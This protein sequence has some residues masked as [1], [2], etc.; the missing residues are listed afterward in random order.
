MRT[1]KEVSDLAGVSV[2]TLQHYDNVGLLKPS[3]YSQAGYRL[4]GDDDLERLQ[5]ILFFKEL[6][7]SLKGIKEI[8]DSE[9]FDKEEALKEQI[10]LLTLKKERLENLIKFAKEIQKEGI[11]CMKFEAFDKEKIERYS[12]EAR[13]KWGQTEAYKEFEEKEKNRSGKESELAVEQLMMIFAEFGKI[14]GEEPGSESAQKLVKKLQEHITKNYYTC[15]NEILLGL[16]KMYAAGGEFTTNIDKYGGD[17][18]ASFVN[19]AIE[20]YCNS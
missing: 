1:V 11:D 2:R 14:K 19:S 13:E 3:S 5:Q 20:T 17:G 15:T 7:F 16:G 6:D 10:K 4:Y 9:D 12:K 18:T 8:L